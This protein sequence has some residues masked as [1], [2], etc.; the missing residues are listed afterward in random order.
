VLT[1]TRPNSPSGA[2]GRSGWSLLELVIAIV[3]ATMLFGAAAVTILR[4]DKAFEETE[5]G[6]ETERLCERALERIAREFMDADRSSLALTPAAPLQ[7][8]SVSY[9][10]AQGWAGGAL[11]LGATRRIRFQLDPAE[12]VNGIDDDGDGSID[13]GVVVLDLDV[14]GGGTSVSLVSGVRALNAGELANGADDNGDGRIDEPGFFAEYDAATATLL[15]RLTIERRGLEG[16]L[17]SRSAQ[18]SV[19]VRNG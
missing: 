13:E 7:A 2:R 14:A 12:T 16:R 6:A 15:L 1:L 5:S 17:V 3:L 18:L 8:T 11:V 19:R 4:A 9:R 10:R